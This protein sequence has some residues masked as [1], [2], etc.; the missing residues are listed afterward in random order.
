MISPRGL[1]VE[2]FGMEVRM[3]DIILSDGPYYMEAYS[4]WDL[5]YSSLEEIGKFV[6]ALLLLVGLFL[7]ARH[8]RQ[9]NCVQRFFY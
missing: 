4:F 8:I 7:L 3:I 6:T 9:K 5:A 2:R 1:S